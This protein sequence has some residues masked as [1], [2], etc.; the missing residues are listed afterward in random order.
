VAAL[1]DPI[2]IA[3]PYE[4]RPGAG[5]ADSAGLANLSGALG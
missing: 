1:Y 4:R 2:G 3:W 5:G